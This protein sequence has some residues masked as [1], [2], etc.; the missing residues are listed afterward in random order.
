MQYSPN[1]AKTVSALITKATHWIQPPE[2]SSLSY[3]HNLLKNPFTIILLSMSWFQ[4]LSFFSFSNNIFAWGTFFLYICSNPSHYILLDS[5]VASHLSCLNHSQLLFP[6][7]FTY[8][9]VHDT[10]GYEDLCLMSELIQSYFTSS[11]PASSI[12][13][14]KLPFHHYCLALHVTHLHFIQHAIHF[15]F[16]QHVRLLQSSGI[17]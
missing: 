9:T 10:T 12:F 15:L 5:S 2:F 1:L 6:E 11:Q 3:I 7:Q 14:F 4:K 16:H 17:D 8:S 13:I